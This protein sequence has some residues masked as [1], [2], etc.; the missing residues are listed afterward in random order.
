[1]VTLFSKI[2]NKFLFYI[3]FITDFVY[4]VIHFIVKS[5]KSNSSEKRFEFN[6]TG[7]YI[8]ENFLDQ[9]QLEAIY[10]EILIC[11]KNNYTISNNDL[12]R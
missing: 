11:D 6:S 3:F 5:Y 10:S 1:M 12:I 2:I 7:F 9:N 4:L 8:N